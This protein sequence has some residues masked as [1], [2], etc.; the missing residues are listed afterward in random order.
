M[1][2]ISEENISQVM[3][4]LFRLNS[5]ESENYPEIVIITEKHLLKKAFDKLSTS[6]IQYVT[7]H[8]QEYNKIQKIKSENDDKQLSLFA[9][10]K[11]NL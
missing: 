7:E 8:W 2:K 3:R 10:Q 9:D 1:T 4:S 11:F 5:F 6:D